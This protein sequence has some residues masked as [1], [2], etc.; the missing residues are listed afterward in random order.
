M[1]YPKIWS[2]LFWAAILVILISPLFYWSTGIGQAA[3]QLAAEISH[4]PDGQ[5]FSS[6]KALAWRRLLLPI[7]IERLII[8]P[9]L[10]L[11]FQ[12]SGRAIALKYYLE[13]RLQPEISKRLARLKY[14]LSRMSQWGPSIWRGS[15]TGHTL[16]V[17]I[18]FII[19]LHLFI[20]LL[21]LPF[22]FYQGFILGHQFGLS[23]QSAPGW[24][25]DWIKRVLI[26][27]TTTGLAWTGFYSLMRLFPHRWPL[28]A[29]GLLILF[30]L[31]FTLLTPILITPLFFNIY[32]LE[33]AHL[34]SRI[35]SMAE[36]VS[37]PVDEVYVI[38]ASAKTTTGNAYL[39]GFGQAQRIIFYDNLLSNY[40]LEQVEVILAHEIGHWFYEHVLWSLLG[41]GIAG[42]LGLFGLRWLLE[43]SWSRLRLTSPDDVAGLPYILAIISIV[44]TLSLPIQNGVSRYAERQADEFALT[45]TQD[46]EAFIEL[47][48]QLA[49]QNLSIVNPPAWEKLIFYSHPSTA[50]RIHLAEQFRRQPASNH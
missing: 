29:G 40:R 23:T 18:L 1:K 42:W 27:L 38:D 37:L 12:F 10:L 9:I 39:A 15:L 43:R 6:P 26:S 49:E 8:Y 45:T 25:G 47:F 46:T 4:Q 24:L 44:T 20:F 36:R 33:D 28:P 48:E 16:T 35:L 3:D 5:L 22:S 31:V 2:W 11:A 32:P 34:R 7:H 30:S 17:T 50:E 13:T 14:P 19:S 21:Y 41:L